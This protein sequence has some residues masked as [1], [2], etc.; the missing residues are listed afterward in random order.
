[1]LGYAFSVA[2]EIFHLIEEENI[3]RHFLINFASSQYCI[4]I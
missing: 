4:H 2:L 3:F 1:M